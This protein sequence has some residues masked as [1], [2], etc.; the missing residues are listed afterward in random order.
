MQQRLKS[1]SAPRKPVDIVRPN[2]RAL[3]RNRRPLTT[4]TLN[5]NPG[6]GNVENVFPVHN[7]FEFTFACPSTSTQGINVVNDTESPREFEP[8]DNLAYPTG[9]AV[10]IA[11][12][13]VR[14]AEDLEPATSVDLVQDH[15]ADP[16][17]PFPL[18][19]TVSSDAT[20]LNIENID[21]PTIEQF[22]DNLVH[23][24][25]ASPS[26]MTPFP[27]ENSN[28]QSTGSYEERLFDDPIDASPSTVTNSTSPD[29]FEN[30][31]LVYAAILRRLPVRII[32]PIN[33]HYQSTKC[34][35]QKFILARQRSRS[36]DFS[37]LFTIER[38]PQPRD[39]KE[40]YVYYSVFF[41]GILMPGLRLVCV[42]HMPTKPNYKLC[43][44]GCTK[45]GI[46]SWLSNTP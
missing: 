18:T 21:T 46:H 5:S 20:S 17:I 38:L 43:A 31:L 25:T 1:E 6:L 8:E 2:R 4:S 3:H 12:D 40:G 23:S 33:N 15:L 13:E 29:D 22:Q 45:D 10:T 41:A 26:V 24:P 28:N 34:L 39:A 7:Q 14:R 30:I 11:S 37:E 9:S 19:S 16:A 32:T 27:P 35:I 42:P 36:T 44:F